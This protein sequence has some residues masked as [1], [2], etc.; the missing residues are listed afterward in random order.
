MGGGNT[1]FVF[2]QDAILLPEH[3]F[4]FWILIGIVCH[5]FPWRVHDNVLVCHAFEKDRE[6]KK[7]AYVKPVSRAK[8]FSQ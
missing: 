1:F 6:R 8:G 7:G 3:A 5:F 4:L 2:E